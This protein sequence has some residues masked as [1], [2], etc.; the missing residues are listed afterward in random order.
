MVNWGRCFAATLLLLSACGG[1]GGGTN[2]ALSTGGVG[3]TPGPA[4]GTPSMGPAAQPGPPTAGAFKVVE[5]ATGLDTPWGLAFLPDGRMLITQRGGQMRLRNADGSPANGGADQ[6]SG[7]PAVAVVGQGG[8]LDVALDPNF[9]G[10]RRIYFSFSESDAANANLNGTAVARAEL[11]AAG[12]SLR[13]LAVIYRQSPK[14]ES[15]AHFGSRLVFDRSGYLFVT[16]GER[17]IDTQRG[18]AQDLS[19]GNGKVV[20]ITTDGAPA[21]GNPF[22]GTAGAQPHIWSYGHRNP[23][24]AALHPSTGELW[25]DEHGPQGGDE[26]NLVLA[27]RNYG[28][29]VISYGQEYGTLTQVGEGTAKAGME[30]P[31]TYWE[32]IDGSPWSPGTAKSSI[33]PSGMA[34]Y[35]GDGLPEWRGNLFVGALAGTALWRLTLN[36]NAVVSRERLLADR[37]ERIRDVRQGPDGALYLLTDSPNGKLLRL[38]H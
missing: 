29:P 7:V 34:F 16:L 9:A 4:P 1:G 13:N 23:Q 35:T 27:G 6:L 28:W 15:T 10:N 36:G 17:Q 32:T 22:V 26:V 21:P 18:F 25:I 24:G 14:V 3:L 37:N 12:M 30:Q 8:L 38:Q 2:V 20:R 33:A 19:R 31:V 11:D 5:V